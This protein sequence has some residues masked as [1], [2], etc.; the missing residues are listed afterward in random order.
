[1]QIII[2]GIQKYYRFE[3][4]VY[5]EHSGLYEL[6]WRIFDNFTNTDIQHGHSFE[7]LQGGEAVCITKYKKI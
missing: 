5:D 4:E 2:T 6:E 3:W 7:S 1:M